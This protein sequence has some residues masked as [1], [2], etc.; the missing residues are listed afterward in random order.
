MIINERE[1]NGVIIREIVY[2]ES[3]LSTDSQKNNWISVCGS[4]E[5]KENDTCG[6]CGCLLLTLMT[7]KNSTCPMGKW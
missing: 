7:Y 1:E 6:S 2:E 5:L 3:D 4:C